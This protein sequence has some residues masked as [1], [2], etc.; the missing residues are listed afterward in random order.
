MSYFIHFEGF[1]NHIHSDFI[2]KKLDELMSIKINIDNNVFEFWENIFEY[3][4]YDSSLYI[5]KTRYI[6]DNL[7]KSFT[8]TSKIEHNKKNDTLIIKEIIAIENHY[9][10]K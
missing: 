4:E 8:I 1:K 6:N 5:V 10:M 9:G 2:S 7:S 3:M